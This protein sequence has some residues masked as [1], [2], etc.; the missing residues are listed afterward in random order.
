MEPD[1]RDHPPYA[2][3]AT[4]NTASIRAP[5]EIDYPDVGTIIEERISFYRSRIS[6]LSIIRD[7]LPARMNP[8]QNRAIYNNLLSGPLH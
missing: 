7:M 6:E 8:E 5:W 2:E 4:M 3:S 1:E